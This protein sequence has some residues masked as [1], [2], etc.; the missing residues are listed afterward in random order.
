MQLKQTD[1][2]TEVFFGENDNY[3][4]IANV[5]LEFDITLRKEENSKFH[6][7]DPNRLVNNA[8][9]FSLK[10]ARLS[11]TIGSDIEH[12]KFCGQVSA[13]MKVLSNKYGDFLSQF[14]SFNGIAIPIL[15]RFA[16][17]LLQI[18]SPLQHKIMKNKHTDANKGKIKGYF[19]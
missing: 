8:F 9:A 18:R 2:N 10:E 12:N 3:H 6:Y 15:E 17:L 19:F 5:F 11:T 1:Q 4:Q 14:D 13:I 7:V 16:D